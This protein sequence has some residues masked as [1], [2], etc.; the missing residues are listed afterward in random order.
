[1]M[2]K[3]NVIY[4]SSNG[5]TKAAALVLAEKLGGSAL[6]VAAVKIADFE[7]ELIIL[8]TSTWGCGELQDDWQAAL[9]MLGQVAWN[10]RR[11]ALFGLGD[12]DA[13]GDSFLDGVRVLYD[14]VRSGG[15]TVIGAWPVDGYHHTGSMAEIDGQFIGLALDDDNQPELTSVRITAWC[16]QLRQAMGW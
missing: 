7:A 16:R 13:F 12:Q 15:A 4:G 9:G 8:G 6:D 14:L 1:M 11:V 10:G 5:N 3:V 2:N